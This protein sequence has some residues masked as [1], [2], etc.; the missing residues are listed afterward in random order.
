MRSPCLV[1]GFRWQSG[2]VSVFGEVSCA[3][4]CRGVI[5]DGVV[6][7]P[8]FVIAGIGFEQAADTPSY[9]GLRDDAQVFGS[10]LQGLESILAQPFVAGLQPVVV[11][12]APHKLH[13]EITSFGGKDSTLVEDG[14][15]LTAGMVVKQPV[16][17][18]NQR[19]GCCPEV[20]GGKRQG[21]RKG[22]RCAAFEADMGRDVAVPD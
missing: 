12:N 15:N 5:G 7:I 13:M 14:G 2:T 4:S 22:M 18:F 8:V 19:R 11:L 17:F 10:L 20:P 6:E 3:D 21:K 16:N 9:D 1:H